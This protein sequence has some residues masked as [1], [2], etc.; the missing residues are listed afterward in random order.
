MECLYVTAHLCVLCVWHTSLHR[1]VHCYIH[2]IGIS[3][4][5]VT[6]QEVCKS[7]VST[8]ISYLCGDII[9]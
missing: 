2:S 3:I 1:L 6:R 7:P 4:P 8:Y 9:F 5:M